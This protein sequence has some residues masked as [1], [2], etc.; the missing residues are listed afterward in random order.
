MSNQGILGIV[1]AGLGLLVTIV[2]EGTNEEKPNQTNV[3]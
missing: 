3:K 2:A 1:I